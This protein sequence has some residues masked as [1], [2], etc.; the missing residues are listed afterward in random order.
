M[1]DPSGIEVIKENHT[2]QSGNV[3]DS[4][5]PIYDLYGRRLQE[6]PSSGF[7]IRNGKKYLAR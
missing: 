2:D 6:I 3:T 7:Y 5:T 1:D 4:D